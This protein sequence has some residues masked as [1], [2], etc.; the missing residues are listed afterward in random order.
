M[1]N[2][3]VEIADRIVNV[4]KA[5]HTEGLKSEELIK[6]KAETA[7]DYDKYIA[8]ATAELKA[9]GE[10]VS[11]IDKLAKGN[12]N[13]ALYKKILAEEMLKAHYSKIE[14]LEAIMNGY[15]SVN[16]YLYS[17]SKAEIL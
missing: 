17:T 15:Q 9:K 3:Q 14:Q 2:T 12:C 16:R 8:I 1:A 6:N 7:R 5:L 10:S 11:I 13:E 4:I